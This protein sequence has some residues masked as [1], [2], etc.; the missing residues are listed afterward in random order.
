VLRLI[1]PAMVAAPPSPEQPCFH[2]A[3]LASFVKPFQVRVV[4]FAAMSPH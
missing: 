3:G 4:T 1:H 2:E